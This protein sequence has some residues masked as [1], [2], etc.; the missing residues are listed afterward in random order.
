MK[1]NKAFKD[2]QQ[3][4]LIAYK[5]VEDGGSE[6]DQSLLANQK[7]GESMKNE[8]VKAAKTAISPK[9]PNSTSTTYS[10]P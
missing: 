10:Q 4:E 2:N 1:T 9:T 8:Y 5:I 3:Q 7:V 6:A